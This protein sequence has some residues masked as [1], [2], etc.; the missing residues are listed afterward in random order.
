MVKTFSGARSWIAAQQMLTGV[1]RRWLA[2]LSGANRCF[3]A[4]H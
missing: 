4:N 3:V 1:V 2:G